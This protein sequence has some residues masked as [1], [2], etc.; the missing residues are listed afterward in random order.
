MDASE[1]IMRN[2]GFTITAMVFAGGAAGAVWFIG[3]RISSDNSPM[4]LAIKVA[5]ACVA[6]IVV[7]VPVRALFS[8]R[9]SQKQYFRTAVDTGRE[10]ADALRTSVSLTSSRMRRA[11]KAVSGIRLGSRKTLEEHMVDAFDLKDV[12]KQEK[13]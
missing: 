9:D 2:A 11:A 12:V 10:T 3:S 13:G 1:S 7:L 5:L 8:G 6:A 4:G